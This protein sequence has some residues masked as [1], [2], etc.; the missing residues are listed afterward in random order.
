M[1]T[2]TENV[3]LDMV[4]AIK[5]AVDPKRIVLFGSYAEG[6]QKTDSDVDFVVIEHEPFGEKRSRRREL[7]KIRRALSKFRIAKDILLFSEEEVEEWRHSHDHILTYAI[8][9]G[10]T[11]YGRS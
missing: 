4:N 11:L 6:C 8:E 3:L 7:L 5:H 9:K 2:I 10:R 1:I